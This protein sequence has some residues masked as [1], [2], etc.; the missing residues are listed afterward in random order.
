MEVAVRIDD[1]AVGILQREA[2]LVLLSD[3][4]E[5]A[6]ACEDL[7]GAV[8]RAARARV[9]VVALG[10]VFEVAGGV[11]A[12]ADEFAVVVAEAGAALGAYGRLDVRSAAHLAFAFENFVN[13]FA[14]T[15][16]KKQQHQKK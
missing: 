10:E 13:N 4:V 12:L 6:L 7:S 11:P 3:R 16:A 2:G 1:V 15:A 8:V 5:A 14:P 9:D